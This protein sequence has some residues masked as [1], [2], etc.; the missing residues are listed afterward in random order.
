M[1]AHPAA[2]AKQAYAIKA[3]TR[4][5]VSYG[6]PE[7]TESD[8]GTHFTSATVQKWAEDNNIEWW[9]HLP[10]NPM[11]AGLREKYNGILKAALKA[12]SQSLQGWTKRL[13]ET[14]QDLNERPRDGRPSALR[15]LQTTWASPL[16]IQITGLGHLTQAAS[17]HH[18]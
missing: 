12:D 14:L 8:Q 7:V 10:Y 3:L 16:R 4:L 9:F 17:W 18:G 1:Q 5:M 11:G 13:Y 15:I 2:K 6:I